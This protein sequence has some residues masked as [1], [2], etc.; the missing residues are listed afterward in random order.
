[1]ILLGP[2]P[3]AGPYAPRNRVR[4]PACGDEYVVCMY[5]SGIRQTQSCAD[6][7]AKRRSLMRRAKAA[8]GGPRA[9]LWLRAAIQFRRPVTP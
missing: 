8:A 7:A 6:C 2:A 4:C 3:G 5:P 1:M 9:P